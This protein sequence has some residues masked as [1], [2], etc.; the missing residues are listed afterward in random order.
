MT[1]RQHGQQ[2]GDT[3]TL[4]TDEAI[5]GIQNDLRFAPR[6]ADVHIVCVRREPTGDRGSLAQS[7]SDGGGCEVEQARGGASWWP[8]LLPLAL[9][10]GRR[11]RS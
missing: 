3:V 2:P 5:G 4:H 9:T 1:G 6:I 8:L 7:T 10:L 11:R